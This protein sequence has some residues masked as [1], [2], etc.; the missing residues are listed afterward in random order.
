[1][2]SLSLKDIVQVSALVLSA[3]DFTL[4]GPQH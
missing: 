3:L 1:M 2:S 4:Q